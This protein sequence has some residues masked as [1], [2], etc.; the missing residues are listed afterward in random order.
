MVSKGKGKYAE[1]ASGG[2]KGGKKQ[3]ES[4][5]KGYNG[6]Q[7]GKG[8]SNGKGK[9]PE[10]S[11]GQASAQPAKVIHAYELEASIIQETKALAAT[12][13]REASK[14]ALECN[15]SYCQVKKHSDMGCAV[16]SFKDQST[17]DTV[18]NLVNARA[19]EKVDEKNKTRKVLPIEG[20]EVQWRE[21]FDKDAE[22]YLVTDIFIAW[23][24]QAEKTNSLD[25]TAIA[26]AVDGLV[27]EAGGQVNGL[28]L[29]NALPP[30]PPPPVH[31][32]Q[33][34][35]SSMVTG[36]PDLYSQ[37]YA[38]QAAQ[39]QAMASVGAL[40]Q[41]AA[42]AVPPETPPRTGN[43]MRADAPTFTLTP[44]P[45]A[46]PADNSQYAFNEYDQYAD[47]HYQSAAGYAELPERKQFKIVDP[48]SGLA[49]EPPKLPGIDAQFQ[50]P[51]RK[52]MKILD[53]SSGDTIDTLGMILTPAKADKK[54]TIIDPKD[55]C[56]IQAH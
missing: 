44:P 40:Q 20:V 30:P 5:G 1:K 15:G 3:N 47:Y 54:F 4:G 25:A 46:F 35:Q 14:Q 24:R 17:R 49:V 56:S 38:Y 22:Q 37:M 52:T 32:D 2:G 7:N 23:G 34:L 45:P 18:L 51:A 19:I 29:S 27:L 6:Y 53:P 12:V 8:K 48:K 55:G 42:A 16:V 28:N 9:K 21:H 10:A 11:K 39:Q 50:S 26:Q 31:A 13:R 36:F 33:L 41:A 43:K